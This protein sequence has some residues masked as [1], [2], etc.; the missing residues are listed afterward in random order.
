MLEKMPPWKEYPQTDPQD[1]V[2]SSAARKV[3]INIA[4]FLLKVAQKVAT[5]KMV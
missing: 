5:K 3:D 2:V 1:W 4:N